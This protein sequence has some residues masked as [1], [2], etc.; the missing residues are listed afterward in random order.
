M[1]SSKTPSSEP[2]MTLVL[3]LITAAIGLLVA[4]GVHITTEQGAAIGGFVAAALALGA[5]VRS[6]VTPTSHLPP[7]E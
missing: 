5:Y 2:V 1:P 6:R 4:F 3:G 7:G